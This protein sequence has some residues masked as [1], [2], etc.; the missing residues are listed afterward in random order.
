MAHSLT[1]R[2][3][4]VAFL[5]VFAGAAA[6]NGSP[7]RPADVV[8]LRHCR[9]SDEAYG[10]L[11]KQWA[12]YVEA[13]PTDVRAWVEWGDALRYL[14]KSI[15]A[16][17]KY[18][19]AY[20]IDPLDSASISAYSV[21]VFHEEDYAWRQMHEALLQ[22]SRRD[23]DF[24][25]QYYTLWTTSLRAGDQET[26]ELSLR[27]M[28]ELGDMPR[29]LL[30]FGGNMIEGSAPG[31]IIITNGDNDTYPPHAYQVISGRRRDVDLI[32]LSLLNTKW[33]IRYLRD[34]GLP[35]RLSDGDI[36]ALEHREGDLIAAQMQRHIFGNLKQ[37]AN[38]RPLYYCVTV[39][40][41][42]KTLPATRHLEG[43]LERVESEPQAKGQQIVNHH[44][45]AQLLSDVYR[46][47]SATDPLLDWEAEGSVARLM[48]NYTALAAKVG[49]ELLA[50][51]EP[52]AAAGPLYLAVKLS[53]F[54]GDKQQA[55]RILSSW[56]AAA[57]NTD[58][59]RR[60]ERLLKETDS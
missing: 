40:E 19:Q 47:D 7:V 28:V 35:I 8:S 57:S 37:A 9:L 34:K 54:F 4:L 49:I 23:P 58:L 46:L 11:E 15:E 14:G 6:C 60:A 16:D 13:N 44:L 52:E 24:V 26:A 38:P 55:E 30:D 50:R 53:S 10:R 29:V 51:N 1:T 42:A 3:L 18:E 12:A 59:Y 36:S 43:L 27:R 22:G 17:L 41:G 2:I 25:E 5:G 45:T 56:K 31:A 39:Y 33:Y 21:R 20:E 32:N 48:G